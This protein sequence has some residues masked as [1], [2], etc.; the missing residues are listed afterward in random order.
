MNAIELPESFQTYDENI[1]KLIMEYL[2]QLNPIELKAYNIAMKH[3][4]SSFNLIKSNG[5]C[6]WVKTKSK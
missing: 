6:D 3:L 2:H 4:G 1:Q 5:Y